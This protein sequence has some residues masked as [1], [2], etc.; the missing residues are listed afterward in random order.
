M[1]NETSC[2]EEKGSNCNDAPILR[3]LKIHLRTVL[4]IFPQLVLE[5]HQMEKRK[6]Q[7]RQHVKDVLSNKNHLP[8]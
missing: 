2:D 5:K 7:G 6:K 4:K 1:S 8:T 3:I